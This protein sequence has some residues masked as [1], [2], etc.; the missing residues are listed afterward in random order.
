M[1]GA[2]YQAYN[3]PQCVD[4]VLANFRKHYPDSDVVLISDGGNDFSELA[5][6]YNCMY[7]YEQNLSGN[8]GNKEKGLS[9][10]YF[11]D[12][13]ILINYVERF[14]KYILQIKQK[15]FMVLEDDVAVLNKTDCSEFNSAIYGKNNTE[16]LPY[17]ICKYLK[18][19]D[20]IAYGGC[21]G[22]LFNTNFF[23]KVLSENNYKNDI[24]KYCSL[25]R[26]RWASDAIIS[27][28]CYLYGGY[29]EEWHKHGNMWESDIQKK[30][31][32]NEIDVL[33]DFKKLY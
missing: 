9:D 11:Y 8:I 7:F 16:S 32:N 19:V 21:G 17:P 15:Y 29:I 33:H 4:F 23:N 12:P 10:Q 18:N 13:Q 31:L 28:I 1:I 27:Y 2:Y 30:L 14:K 3:K 24:K 6:K 25:T 22:C 5:A 20:R 26:E